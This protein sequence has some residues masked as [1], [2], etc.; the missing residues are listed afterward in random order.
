MNVQTTLNFYGRTEEAVNFYCRTLEAE[1][2]FMM[3][4]R[5]RP[6]AAQLKPGLEEKIFTQIFASVPLKSGRQTA[7]VKIRQPKQT[8]PASRCFSGLKLQKKPNDF[9]RRSAMADKSK[10]LCKNYFSPSATESS[11]IALAS[12]GK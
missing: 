10:C 9:S 11:L 12:P 3:R 7:V 2:L 6:D 5:E 4:F 1:I 8:L